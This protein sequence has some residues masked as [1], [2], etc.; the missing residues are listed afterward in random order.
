M[1]LYLA[2]ASPRRRQPGSVLRHLFVEARTMMAR[3]RAFA[4]APQK[5]L[6]QTL[7]R[8]HYA[9]IMSADFTL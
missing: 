3:C 1:D 8:S 9:H 4:F 6:A 2:S 7:L 5:D